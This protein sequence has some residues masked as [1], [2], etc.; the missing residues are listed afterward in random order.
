MPVPKEDEELGMLRGIEEDG[1]DAIA[2]G[3]E[4]LGVLTAMEEERRGMAPRVLKYTQWLQQHSRQ[5][6]LGSS[7]HSKSNFTILRWSSWQ[8]K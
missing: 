3:R 2:A 4:T 5:F 8:A 6:T 1:P 7:P